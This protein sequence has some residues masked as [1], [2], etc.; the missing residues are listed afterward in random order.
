MR[1]GKGQSAIEY[2]TTYGWALL[3][4]AVV[5]A[6]F[7]SLGLFSNQLSGTQ[8]IPAVGFLCQAP[9]LSTSGYLSFIFGQNTG[10]VLYNVELACV[11]S[12]DSLGLPTNSIAWQALQAN[13]IM[14][15][16]VTN[17]LV[18]N[19]ETLISAQSLAVTQ[20]RC[21]DSSGNLLGT[22][23][24]GQQ[25]TEII[26]MNYTPVRCTPGVNACNWESARIATI[27]VKAS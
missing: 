25:Y 3:V 7:F 16:P 18:N 19:A 22:V 20:M 26:W 13:G 8:C 17:S 15:S 4:T 12:V 9:I 27:T 6:A 24:I 1:K 11:S 23:P 21:Y 10:Q 14:V 5:L 2:L